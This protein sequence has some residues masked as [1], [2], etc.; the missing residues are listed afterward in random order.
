MRLP[1]FLFMLPPCRCRSGG[2]AGLSLHAAAALEYSH[3]GI[4]P[5][6]CSH[7]RRHACPGRISCPGRLPVPADGH[8]LPDC[9]A[10]IRKSL[11]GQIRQEERRTVEPQSGNGKAERRLSAVRQEDG[12]ANAVRKRSLLPSCKPLQKNRRACRERRKQGNQRTEE[13]QQNPH[14][15]V[16]GDGLPQENQGQNRRKRRLEEEDQ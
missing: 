15:H 14:H 5:S 8:G 7:G 10:A 3:P 9:G 1:V 11:S 2:S 16:E 12:E 4:Q 6:G 13:N